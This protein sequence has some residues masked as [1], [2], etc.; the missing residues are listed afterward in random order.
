MELVTEK[1]LSPNIFSDYVEKPSLFSNKKSLTAAFIPSKIPHRD[2]EITQLTAVLAPALRGYHIN[3]VFIYGTCG[4]GK[5]ICSRFVI[6]QLE[7]I[8]KKNKNRIKTVYINC[9]M[10]KVAD[11]E[12]RLFAQLLKELGETVPDTGL[13]TDV[14][15]R[16][17]FE[18][19]DK[20]KQIMII[21]LDEIDALFKKVGDDFLYNLTR[22]NTE[23]KN[24][25]LAII[26]ITNDLSF[27]DKLD[28]R[29]KSSL[30]E[31]EMLFKPYN[32][33]QLKNILEE[34]VN[35]GFTAGVVDEAVL[36]K[37]AALAAQEHG[38]ARRALDLLRVAGEIA[39]R[40]GETSIT[41]EHVDIAEEKIDMDRV[42]ETVKTQPKQSQAVLYSILK[43]NTELKAK[44]KWVDSRLLT[45]DIYSLYKQICVNNNLKQLTQRRVSDLISELD[46]LSIITTKVISKGRYG[47]TRDISLAV[48]EHVLEKI[49]K[50]LTE[51][52]G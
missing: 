43:L 39:E 12:Y 17:F 7:D 50:F 23:L 19:V 42:T 28:I 8:A 30:S 33:L 20:D 52:F 24:S 14:L 27:R 3:N 18:Q 9:K 10:K 36:N 22:I 51:R 21:V 34:R 4:T 48:S 29:V 45:G 37:C 40:L 35:N 38:D 41:E 11:T 47:R 5:T 1:S 31:E 15:Y 25:S 44:E 49:T 26:G 32:A 6:S 13:P 46:M 2:S 16:K